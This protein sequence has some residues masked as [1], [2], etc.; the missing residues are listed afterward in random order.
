MSTGAFATVWLTLFLDLLAFGIILPVTPYYAES[1]GASV[2]T[3]TLLSTAFSLAQFVC[4]PLLGRLSDRVG[5]RPVMLVSIAGSVIAHLTLFLSSTLAMV[6]IARVFAGMSNA[7]VATAHAY[8]ADRVEPEER[9]RA[10]GW[11]GSAIG[12]G[13]VCGPA[14]GGLL[15]TAAT[16]NLPFLVAAILAAVN[17]AM[18]WWLLPESR[19]TTARVVAPTRRV[20]LS[21]ALGSTLWRTPLGWLVLVNCGF[22]FVFAGMES[23]FALYCEAAFG[24]GSQQMGTLYVLIGITIMLTQ[25]ALVGRVVGALGEKRTVILGMSIL[26]FGLAACATAPNV[27]VLAVGAAC[28]AVGNGL[29]T[30]CVSALVSR[31]AQPEQQGWAQGLSQSSAALARI[32]API[33]AGR[34][35]EML[36]AG[37]PM[38]VGAVLLL[39]LCLPVVALAIRP[40]ESAA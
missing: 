11:M 32:G 19:R 13:F 18:A 34:V 26:A 27:G 23:T 21:K 29:S 3:V 37:V 31:V 33:A 25:G 38:L 15:S 6:F 24:W 16:P 28:I 20:A 12:L 7:N 35:F 4:A 2:A 5:R 10:M 39:T 40:A 9:A 30:P 36:G 17:F 14:L 22:F 1:F 8:V